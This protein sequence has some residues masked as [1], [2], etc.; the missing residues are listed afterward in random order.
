LL[1]GLVEILV[2][3]GHA[4]LEPA[5]VL[6]D[7]TA[8]GVLSV[9]ESVFL[10]REHFQQLATTGEQGIEHPGLLVGQRS[11]RGTDP[12]GEQGKEEGVHAV[13]LGELPGGLGEVAH[14][15]GIGDNHGEAGRSERGRRRGFVSARGFQ[16]DQGR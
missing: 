15:S 9:G 6:G 4:A 11:H 5:D 1:D 14:L 13:G 8:H 16:D 12:F 2:N 10:S 3:V 7:V